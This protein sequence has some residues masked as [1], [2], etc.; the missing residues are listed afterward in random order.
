MS[1]KVPIYTIKESLRNPSGRMRTL[2]GLYA[3]KDDNEALRFFSSTHALNFL[4]H[5][6]GK[7][8]ILKYF[9]G[10]SHPVIE[11]LRRLD[12]I[13]EGVGYDFLA[14]MRYMEG[15]LLVFGHDGA[16]QWLD[17]VLQELP[18]GKSLAS[19]IADC[20]ALARTRELYHLFREICVLANE[21]TVTSFVHCNLKPSN[22][23]VSP[24]GKPM[25]INY[26][27]ARDYLCA[28]DAWALAVMAAVSYI[29]ACEP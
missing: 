6:S 16:G 7:R 15:E 8:Y 13:A 2:R 10:N 18:E 22:V 4:V 3:E 14:T 11:N 24:D 27:T 5:W 28:T 12:A 25:L 29:C 21:M 17:I 1:P 23:I 20:A 19:F 26:E 9:N